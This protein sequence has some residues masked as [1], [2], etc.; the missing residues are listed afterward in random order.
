MSEWPRLPRGKDSPDRHLGLSH[1]IQH[2]GSTRRRESLSWRLVTEML[3]C[4]GSLAQGGV[5]DAHLLSATSEA[6]GEEKFSS[7]LLG[8]LAGSKN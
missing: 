1:F 8:S 4:V 3:F 7:P 5:L 2:M 6:R